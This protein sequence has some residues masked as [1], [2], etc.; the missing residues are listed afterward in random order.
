MTRTMINQILWDQFEV[1]GSTENI[2]EEMKLS[3]FNGDSLDAVEILMFLEDEFNI[4]IP[5]EDA[6]KWKT[7]GDIYAYVEG[8]V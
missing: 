1:G 2:H 4:E 8:A 7:V 3:E 5:D 6:E